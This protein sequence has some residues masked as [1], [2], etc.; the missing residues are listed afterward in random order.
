MADIPTYPAGQWPAG[1]FI[2]ID[3]KI[4]QETKDRTIGNS[5][6]SIYTVISGCSAYI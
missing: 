2:I 3:R 4:V 5:G 6:R 1:L